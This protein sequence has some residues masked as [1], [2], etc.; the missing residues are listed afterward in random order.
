MWCIRSGN[1]R[2]RTTSFAL[3][4]LVKLSSFFVDGLGPSFIC[5]SNRRL[6]SNKSMFRF[7]LNFFPVLRKSI[8]SKSVAIGN[9]FSLLF[10]DYDN[11]KLI[12]VQNKRDIRN[13]HEKPHRITYILSKNIFHQKSVWGA[14]QGKI[15]LKK[16]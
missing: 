15:S 4:N 16:H 9:R 12:F 5:H 6:T 14:P 7:F 1:S 13:Q 3:P 8:L 11:H 2:D 10:R